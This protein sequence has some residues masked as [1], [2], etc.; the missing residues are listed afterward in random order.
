MKH[1]TIPSFSEQQQ[2]APATV[3]K[4]SVTCCLLA[5]AGVWTRETL[6]ALR[7]KKGQEDQPGN[8][9]PLPQLGVAYERRNMKGEALS[10]YRTV[11][12]MEP[13]NETAPQRHAL[14]SGS[15]A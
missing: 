9:R 5:V 14:L 6:K 4:L 10:I 1:P 3:M 15:G 12:G 13:P 2:R 7:M 8:V 11:T